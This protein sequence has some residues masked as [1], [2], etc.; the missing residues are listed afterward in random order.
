M[1]AYVPD[2]FWSQC[3]ACNGKQVSQSH[4]TPGHTDACRA[5]RAPLVPLTFLAAV[6]QLVGAREVYS[7]GAASCHRGQPCQPWPH[8]EGDTQSRTHLQSANNLTELLSRMNHTSWT[9]LPLLSNSCHS[10]VASAR[11]HES[12]MASECAQRDPATTTL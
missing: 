1:T 12:L 8:F 5:N 6:W 11:H 4:S 2:E 7:N 9:S 3:R 10:H